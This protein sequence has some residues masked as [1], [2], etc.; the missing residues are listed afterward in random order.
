MS[1][2]GNVSQVNNE[3]LFASLSPGGRERLMEAAIRRAYEEGQIVA[4]RGEKWPFLFQ[5]ESGKI[6]A[7]KESLEGRRLQVLMVGPGE[8]F[9][10]LAFFRDNAPM[11]VTL[12][13]ATRSTVLLWNRERL[14][15]LLLEN[16]RVMWELCRIMVG[17]MARA[18]EIVEDL[19][20]QPV[21]GRLARLL[22]ERYE[23]ATTGPVERDLTLDEMAARI[24]TTR[25]MVC[26]ILYRFSDDNLIEITRTE[27]RLSDRDAL[28]Q[29][30][31][32]QK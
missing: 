6:R 32:R 16:S 21:A 3:T 31:G 27:F 17:R 25:E 13:A 12:Q 2:G 28:T 5:V 22:L 18:S 20:F 1:R 19:A 30:A 24:G 23:S 26:R 15:P 9:W 7:E 8:L 10:G 11:P 29:L 4:V 14:L